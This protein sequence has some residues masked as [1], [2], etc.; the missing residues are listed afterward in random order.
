MDRRTLRK[1]RHSR[2]SRR[3][4]SRSSKNR[5]KSLIRV[6]RKL[7]PRPKPLK[8]HPP[9]VSKKYLSEIRLSAKHLDKQIKDA[10]LLFTKIRSNTDVPTPSAGLIFKTFKKA[11]RELTKGNVFQALSLYMTAY[12]SIMTYMPKNPS[13]K[14]DNSNFSH[15]S[16]AMMSD[17][18]VLLQWHS[19]KEDEVAPKVVKS[20]KSVKKHKRLHTIKEDDI[21]TKHRKRNKKHTFHT[22]KRLINRRKRSTYTN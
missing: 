7:H 9:K 8:L 1:K 4:K 22:K 12:A 6:N 16:F 18:D 14:I 17:P 21:P 15:D 10:E 13:L 5:E 20:I 3:R 19:W 11:K 2:Q